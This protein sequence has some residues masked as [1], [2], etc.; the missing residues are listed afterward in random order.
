MSDTDVVTEPADDAH[1][2]DLAN[3]ADSDASA[4]QDADSLLVRE[5]VQTGWAYALVNFTP[6]AASRSI[7]G[8]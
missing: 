5:G 3:R 7:L 2:A 8:V 6:V 1:S 4:E